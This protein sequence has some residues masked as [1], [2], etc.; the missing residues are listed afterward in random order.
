MADQQQLDEVPGDRQTLEA[1]VAALEAQVDALREHV[2]ASAAT[3][4]TSAVETVEPVADVERFWA[5]HGLR[6]RLP[7]PGGVLFTGAV[8]LPPGEQAIWQWT[9]PTTELLDSDWAPIADRLSALAHPVRMELLRHILR[10]VRSSA[11]L[12][13]LD[14]MGT[15]GQLYHHLNQLTATGW[16]RQTGR[17]RYAVPAQR[18]V[19]LLVVLS[20]SRS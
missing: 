7:S 18:V 13:Q 6:E 16:L 9:E 4:E 11:E 5:L 10:G 2:L 19:P 15:T 3:R 20:A 17:G 14:V 12:A 1:R 8:E